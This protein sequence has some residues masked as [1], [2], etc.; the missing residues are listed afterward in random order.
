MAR[1]PARRVPPPLPRPR[2]APLRG[3]G[4]R[5]RHHGPAWWHGAW[6]ARLP[7]ASRPRPR[8]PTWKRSGAAPCARP[9][10][11]PGAVRPR[12]AAPARALPSRLARSRP[13]VVVAPSLGAAA[14]CSPLHG[15]EL[16]PACLWRA[17]LSSASGRPARSVPAWPRC[18]SWRAARCVR[19]SA[20]TCARLVRGTLA[21]LCAR[22]CSRGAH[23]ALHGSPCPWRARLPLDVPVPR[24]FH[25]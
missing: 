14:A 6:R 4:A 25:A 2:R 13:G 12:R 10:P 1:P 24:V 5:P 21:R 22:T 19:S 3:H 17:G 8:G 16:G 11:L 23:G 7:A 18:R 20:P 15:L 9:L